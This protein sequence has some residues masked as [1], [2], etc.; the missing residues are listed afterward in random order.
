MDVTRRKGEVALT[1]TRTIAARVG[2][3]NVS[4]PLMGLGVLGLALATITRPSDAAAAAAQ[5]WPPFVLVTGLLLVGVVAD[6]DGVFA[7]AGR[8]FE[9]TSRR[10]ATRFLWAMIAVVV[11][12]ATLNLD[13]AV[14]FLTPVLAYTGLRASASANARSSALLYGC[15]LL[16]N[17]GSLFLP[18]SNLTN[19]LVL[20]AHPV[21]GVEFAS[22]MWAPALGA[23]VVTVI[24]VAFFERRSLSGVKVTDPASPAAGSD[25]DTD[26]DTDTLTGTD[27]GERRVRALGAVAAVVAAAAI[28][29]TR[30]PA[31]PVAVIGAVVV[32]VRL[33]GHTLSWE[34]VRHTVGA[35]SLIG[36]FGVA[37][38][39]GTLG[40]AW[41]GPAWLL[42]R[43]DIWGTG[44]VAAVAAILVNNLPAASLL[45]AR[46]PAHPF[47]LLVGLDVGPNALAT[48]SL[49][50]L[51][52]WRAAGLAGVRPS[53]RRA[54]L[55][56]AVA[57]PLAL[58]VSLA[59]LSVVSG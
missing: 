9:R 36:L 12:T 26:S 35:P 14:A 51:L 50:W 3:R 19:L 54:C 23:V 27:A 53:L 40:R 32:G 56:G 15:V 34:R 18:G 57:M 42:G 8:W 33:R 24:I 37:V 1:G 48:G 29:V 16:A 46:A 4:G 45:S 25:S 31:I 17:A 59:L 2:V 6:E 44:A 11:V 38:A 43:L 13:T 28:L 41:G 52:W 47:A 21:T 39:F 55:I 49:A 10:P 20:G 58:A 5:D 7:G 22:T 30:N